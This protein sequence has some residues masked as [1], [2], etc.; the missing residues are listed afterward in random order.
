MTLDCPARGAAIRVI[1]S[2]I[3]SETV[4][5]ISS[6]VNRSCL[7]FSREAASIVRLSRS[8]NSLPPRFR[9]S[10]HAPKNPLGGLLTIPGSHAR[11]EEHTSEL[12][13]IMRITNA[14]Y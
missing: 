6:R 3:V 7:S 5:D 13:Y 4:L 8:R 14:D 11:S 10:V 12:Q 9:A 2:P 1:M